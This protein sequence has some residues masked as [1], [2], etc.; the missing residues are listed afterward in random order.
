[1]RGGSSPL[2]ASWKRWSSFLLPS[3]ALQRA[4]HGRFHG[5]SKMDAQHQGHCDQRCTP[6][7]TVG[8]GVSA[9][10]RPVPSIGGPRLRWQCGSRDSGPILLTQPARWAVLVAS[11]KYS[12]TTWRRS[13]HGP[14]QAAIMYMIRKSGHPIHA[15]G[16]ESIPP[17]R[18]L[19]T[20]Q[21]WPSP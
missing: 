4:G 15:M 1:M 8:E 14:Q 17:K 6:T 12:G 11:I 2:A 20:Q 13:S 5:D 21:C 3:T 18:R 19:S 7:E 16:G 9:K 10:T